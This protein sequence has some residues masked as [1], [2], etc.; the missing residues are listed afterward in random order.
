MTEGSVDGNTTSG[1]IVASGVGSTL[2]DCDGE[3]DG[4]T[5]GCVI[6]AVAIESVGPSVVELPHEL[7]SQATTT[8]ATSG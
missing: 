2:E 8:K 7:N 4:I 3:S 1:E 5:D 6:G